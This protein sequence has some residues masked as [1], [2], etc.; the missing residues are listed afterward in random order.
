MPSRP[1]IR[2][3]P[4]LSAFPRCISTGLRL[5]STAPVVKGVTAKDDI[6]VIRSNRGVAP[7]V[8]EPKVA[9]VLSERRK[10]LCFEGHYWFDVARTDGEISYQDERRPSINLDKN[11]KYWALP[12]PKREFN[13]NKNLEQNP[14]YTK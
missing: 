6:N 10:E 3:T 9:T 14:G 11:S 2:A 5:S 7:E 13:V 1:L 4:S 12:I 8:T